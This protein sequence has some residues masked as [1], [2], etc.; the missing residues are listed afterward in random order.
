V[1]VTNSFFCGQE[2]FLFYKDKSGR[3]HL[4]QAPFGFYVNGAFA[5][6]RP[7]FV[8][9]IDECSSV[10]LGAVITGFFTMWRPFTELHPL[11]AVLLN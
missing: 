5:G 11:S 6:G 4:V 9:Q 1:I 7:T 2:F 10:E 8:R 3:S